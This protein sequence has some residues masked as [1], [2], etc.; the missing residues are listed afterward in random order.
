MEGLLLVNVVVRKG[1]FGLK[2]PSR[3]HEI[4]ILQLYFVL[5]HDLFL[6]LLDSCGRFDVDFHL[7]SQIV[8]NLDLKVV[9][10]Q[11]PNYEVVIVLH[12]NVEELFRLYRSNLDCFDSYKGS[13][14]CF[15]LV[16][17]R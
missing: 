6:Q 9:S 5:L 2:Y 12:A 14:M 13:R 8:F 17:Y 10:Y 1:L 7:N 15:E 11:R 16:S 4:F 3:K